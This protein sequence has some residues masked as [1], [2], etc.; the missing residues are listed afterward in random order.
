MVVRRRKSKPKI[1]GSPK[2]AIAAFDKKFD[3][4]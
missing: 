2:N 3:L 4:A 1:E